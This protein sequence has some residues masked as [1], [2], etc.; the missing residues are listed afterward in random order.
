MQKINGEKEGSKRV[1]KFALEGNQGVL[2]EQI[3]FFY[4][5]IID[6]YVSADD[7]PLT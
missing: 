1:W 7:F 2:L 5:P 4:F 3:H 6:L